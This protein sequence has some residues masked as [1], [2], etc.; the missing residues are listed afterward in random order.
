MGY[1][2]PRALQVNNVTPEYTNFWDNG[3]EGNYWSNYNGTDTDNDGVGDT[4]LP[5]EGADNCPLMNL[6]WNS[7]DTNHD[8]KV[9]LRDIGKSAKAFG[10]VSGD[11]LW[12]PHAEITGLEPLVPDGKVDMRDIGL[13]ARHFGEHHP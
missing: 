11:A 1:A 2:T 6:Y 10:T 9:D 3:C 8:L 12:N 5:W 7:C 13:I 4:L